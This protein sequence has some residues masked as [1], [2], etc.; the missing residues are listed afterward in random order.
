MNFQGAQGQGMGLEAAPWA[1]RV[2]W[3]VQRGC[4]GSSK[5]CCWALLPSLH[6]VQPSLHEPCAEFAWSAA[7]L[8]GEVQSAEGGEKMRERAGWV[9]GPCQDTLPWKGWLLGPPLLFPLHVQKEIAPLTWKAGLPCL[10]AKQGSSMHGH[11]GFSTAR[12]QHRTT[13]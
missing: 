11:R 6:G 9:G 10:Q 7:E 1:S 4:C 3:V 5:G 2:L 13:P 8:G 12:E